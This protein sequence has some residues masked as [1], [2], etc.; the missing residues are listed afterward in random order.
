MSR[1]TAMNQFNPKLAYDAKNIRITARDG[2]S[3]LLSVSNERGT[4]EV[5]VTARLLG[6]PIGFSVLNNYLILFTTTNVSEDVDIHNGLDHIYRI[7][8]DEVG[9]NG[10]VV[11]LF[12]GNLNFSTKSPIE[13]LPLYENE[14]IQKVYWVDGR[15]QP[16]VINIVGDPIT[17][18]PDVVNF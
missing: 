2:N 1:D 4:K 9:I 8:F 14:S 15:N 16:R 11:E 6:T 17:T 10:D 13:T 5:E 3:T 18:N 12:S 7:S